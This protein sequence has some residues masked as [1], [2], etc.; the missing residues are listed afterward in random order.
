MNIKIRKLLLGWVVCGCSLF[1]TSASADLTMPAILAQIRLSVADLYQVGAYEEAVN[2]LERENERATQEIAA[3]NVPAPY[4]A[5]GISSIVRKATERAED[6]IRNLYWGKKKAV[7]EQNVAR[8]Q[9]QIR[10][11]QEREAQEKLLKGPQPPKA[12]EDPQ[13]LP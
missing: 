11:R 8:L 10:E 13:D 9:Q 2:I 12:P 3:L 6:A 5:I 7:R 1:C 4:A